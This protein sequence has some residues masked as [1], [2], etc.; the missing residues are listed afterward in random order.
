MN[1]TQT[2][3]LFT[4]LTPAQAAVVEGGV[5]LCPYTTKGVKDV[6]NIRFGPSIEAPIAGKWYPGQVKYLE[7]PGIIKNG[8]RK[9]S[10][11]IS[12]KPMWVSTKFIQ[13]ARGRCEPQ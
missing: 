12:A 5:S 4:D 6:L 10:S 9:F 11:S 3:H 1:G 2:E 13:R 7:S 8:F